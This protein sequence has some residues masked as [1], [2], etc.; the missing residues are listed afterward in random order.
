MNKV[1]LNKEISCLYLRDKM[2]MHTVS[3]TLGISVGTVYNRIK[4]MG[5]KTRRIGDYPVSKNVLEANKRNG[6]IN[7]GKKRTIEQ[8]KRI[9]KALF[10]GGIGHKKKRSDGYIQ[11]YFPDHPRST[12]DG[13][14]MEHILVMEASIGRHLAADEV[15]HHKNFK[16][17]DNRLSNLQLMTKH[18]HMSYHMN[19]RHRKRR[20]ENIS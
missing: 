7:R 10:K 2:P 17:D 12:R 4:E 1:I 14:I 18:T 13:Y 8:R 20:K 15:V 3:D 11:V 5:I 19:L 6:L 9:S 16:R